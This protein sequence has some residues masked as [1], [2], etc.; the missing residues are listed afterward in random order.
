MVTAILEVMRY[1]KGWV[2]SQSKRAMPLTSA[3]NDSDA[4]DVR[5]SRLT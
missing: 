2:G 5:V 3:D 4:G 1:H